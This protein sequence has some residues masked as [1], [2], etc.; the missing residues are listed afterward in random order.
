MFSKITGVVCLAICALAVL[1]N[2]NVRASVIVA[3]ETSTSAY[4]VSSTDLLQT[5]FGSVVTVGNF[6]RENAA[7]ES[8]LRNGSMGTMGVDYPN[9]AS[10]TD[11]DILTYT[12]DTT[13]NTGGYDLT[14]IV[15]YACQNTDRCF[16]A[17]GVSVHK[18]GTAA[19]VFEALGSVDY[20]F[21]TNSGYQPASKVSMTDSSG[22]LASGVDQVKFTFAGGQAGLNYYNMYREIDVIGTVAPVPEPATLALLA[23]GLIGLCC[24][25]RRK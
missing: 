20:V 25:T 14:S 8:V 2:A 22:V 21:G 9:S 12:L 7:G 3:G 11:G 1:P 17:Y 19:G 15:A 18:V 6:T 10:A 24:N 16:Q 23:V 13:T 5:G 4:T